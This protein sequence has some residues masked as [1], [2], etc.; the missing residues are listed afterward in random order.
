MDEI[1]IEEIPEIIT[2]TITEFDIMTLQNVVNITDDIII[3]V[4]NVVLLISIV[5][6]GMIPILYAL[7][8]L[9]KLSVSF[10]TKGR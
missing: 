10:I 4:V 8:S 1:I 2:D 3:N 9:I 7:R 6:I 5:I